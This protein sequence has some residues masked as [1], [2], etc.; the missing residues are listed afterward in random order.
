MVAVSP[1]ARLVTNSLS[2]LSDQPRGRSKSSSMSVMGASVTFSSVT[3]NSWPW[4]GTKV[5]RRDRESG[6]GRYFAA[7]MFACTAAIAS[8]LG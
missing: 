4:P 6:K 7:A 2:R 8:S 1:G 3:A 5:T